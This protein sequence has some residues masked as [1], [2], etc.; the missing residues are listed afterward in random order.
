MFRRHLE[1][2]V[3]ALDSFDGFGALAMPRQPFS[4]AVVTG[5][6]RSPVPRSTAMLYSLN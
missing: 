1:H 2:V 3:D 4:R 6:L 5:Y